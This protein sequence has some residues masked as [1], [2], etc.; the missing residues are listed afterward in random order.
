MLRPLDPTLDLVFKLLFTRGP[1]SDVALRG[2]LTA[3]LAPPKPIVA[4]RVRNPKL[5]VAEVDDK[6][7]TMC[8]RADGAP[9]AVK[10]TCYALDLASGAW[11]SVA[12]APARVT[13]L[14]ASA[15]GA[16][17]KPRFTSNDSPT[18][19]VCKKPATA[20]AGCRRR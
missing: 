2:L 9:E 6:A 16:P 19:A 17:F 7:V 15:W 20:V 4:V 13:G 1:K 5:A 10:P 18:C 8:V 3:V 11:S 12:A 14:P